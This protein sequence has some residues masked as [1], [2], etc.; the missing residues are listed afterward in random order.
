MKAARAFT[1][2]EVLVALAIF[3]VVAASV[4]AASA[5]SLQGAARLE[6]KTLAMWIADNQLTDL[7]LAATPPAD[8][9][10]E[11][12]VDFAGRRWRWRSEIEPTSEPD[13]R[14]ATVWVAV[15]ERGGDI[16]DSAL[17]R[18]AGFVGKQ[19]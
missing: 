18:L 9:R 12:Q 8:G 7:Q 5:R 6:D 11:G 1:L 15:G 16:V 14:R 19:P 10:S 13:M 17:V 4:L 2:L 3:A